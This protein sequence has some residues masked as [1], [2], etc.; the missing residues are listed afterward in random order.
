[1][2]EGIMR[3]ERP[4]QRYGHRGLGGT[5]LIAMLLTVVFAAG[6]SLSAGAGTRGSDGTQWP[7]GRWTLHPRTLGAVCGLG[8]FIG[9]HHAVPGTA[10]ARLRV[11]LARLPAA[12]SPDVIKDD[13]PDPS[14]GGVCGHVD[15]PLDRKHPN[16]G[17]IPIFFELFTHTG[18]GSA[19]SAILANFGG[20]GFGATTQAPLALYIF[21][22]DL[23][24]HDI[25]LIDDRGRG[26]SAPIDCAELQHGGASFAKAEA[27]CAAQLGDAASRYGTG[28]IAKD[29]ETVR[30]ALGYDKVDYYGWSAG[31]QDV[32]A[33]A[34]RFGSHLRS[35]V[36]DAPYGPPGLN[37]LRI[38][39]DRT[40]AESRLV[41]LACSTSPTCSVDH[42][43]PVA[44]LDWLIGYIQGHPVE[45]DTYDANGNLVHVRIDATKLLAFVIDDAIGRFVTSGE[46]VA[47]ADALRHGDRAPLLRLGA[48]TAFPLAGAADFGDP[49]FFSVGALY[50]TGCVDAH[51]VWDWSAPIAERKAQLQAAVDALPDDY[52]SPYS[53]AAAS[54]LYFS[55]FAK[56]CIWWQKPTP[57][58]PVTPRNPVYP[59]VPTV[60]LDGI[61]DNR[62]VLAQARRVAN[63]FPDA[64]FIPVAGSGHGTVFWTECA[65]SIAARFIETLSTG[66]T[67]CAQSPETVWPAV[68]RFP[69]AAADARPATPSPGGDNQIPVA[70]RKAVTVALAAATDALQRSSIS[71]TGSSTCLRAGS[72]QTSYGDAWTTTLTG[73]SFAADVIVDGTVTWNA[74]RTVSGDL[75]LSGSGTSGGSL[76][77][78]GSW[79]ASGPVGS[80]HITGVL[81]GL[82]VDV[83]LREA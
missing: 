64:T 72:F 17:T 53:K 48:E 31:G 23:D 60:V 29:A 33:Y 61:M 13:C 35:I 6:P 1:M 41:R 66:D 15:V 4:P 63:L 75:D 47:A 81:G 2:K 10:R 20:P 68:G 82:T 55:I 79:Q 62:V 57:S 37:E 8:I 18:Q 36:L 78:D 73:C 9:C 56:P 30:A 67:S 51:E 24:K 25:L 69:L 38:D 49:T 42:G 19:E 50:G 52:F 22:Q 44:D 26:F 74:D 40:A 45:G 43:N 71:Y 76:H 54:S 77:V 5:A 11:G 80:F 46:I 14:L 27:D 34:T 59:H 58:S 16:D 12:A 83:L 7:S 39:H 28:D 70:E 3:K 65:R 32:S 21:G